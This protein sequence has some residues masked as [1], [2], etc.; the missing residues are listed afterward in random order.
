M[1]AEESPLPSQLFVR[2]NMLC[3]LLICALAAQGVLTAPHTRSTYA[4]K[5]VHNAPATWAKTDR[6]H[7]DHLIRLS[8][9]LE[10]GNFDELER[11]LYEVSDPFHSRYG[12]HL[13]VDEVNELVKPKDEALEAVHEWLEDAGVD[14]KDLE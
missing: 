5:D 9:G 6:A 12:K 1:T 4:V 11:H 14:V 7:P 10:Q 3:S 13:T 8:I 2:I